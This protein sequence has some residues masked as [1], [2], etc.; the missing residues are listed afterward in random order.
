[1][2]NWLSVVVLPA[3]RKP[4]STQTAIGLQGVMAQS[5]KLTVVSAYG[6]TGQSGLSEVRF[7]ALPVVASEPS[8][9]D[10]VTT[11]DIDVHLSWR[12]GR[13]AASHEVYL[14]TDA[15]S[16]TLLDTT[17]DATAVADGLDYMT[18]YVWSV[19][20]V[21]DAADP[22]A[23]AGNLWTFTTSAFAVVED[24]ESYTGNEGEEVFMTWFDGFGGDASLGGSTTGHIDAPFVETATVNSGFQSMPVFIDND[25]GFIDID[26][27]SSSPTVSEV[28]REFSPSQ[29]WTVSGLKTLSI[30]FS[31][32][33]GLSGQLYC[34]IGGTKIL[35]DGDA[36]NLGIAAWQIWNIDLSAMG[37][38]L[39]SVREMAIGVE[40]GGEG[41]LYIDDIR[42]YASSLLAHY[43]LDEGAGTVAN[44]ASGNG[45]NGSFVGDPVW[46]PGQTG[47]ALQFD[48]VDDYVEIP[49]HKGLTVGNEVTV[50]LWIN[51]QRYNSAGEGWGGVMAK[52][53]PRT[54]SLFTTSTGTL[55]FSTAGVG[56]TSTDTVPLNE[57]SHVAA[58]HGRGRQSRLLHQRPTLR[59]WWGQHRSA[60]HHQYRTRDHRQHR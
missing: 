28:M 50:A 22:T 53:N 58:I 56:T 5:V 46:V 24:F 25:G 6:L 57:W 21:N 35:Y 43:P 17:P 10:G 32:S 37:G 38:N 20:E 18:T 39:T 26:G 12:P 51:P 49:H 4:V 2:S 1:M 55:H 60:R 27:K 54:Y 52:G 47:T 44:D 7:M 34:K 41:V 30:S 59:W 45:H 16:M 42:L 40:G 48:G 15:E 29:D 23:H 13:E 9:A 19:T 14:G 8:P 31:G 33:E 36:A 3:P 11:P